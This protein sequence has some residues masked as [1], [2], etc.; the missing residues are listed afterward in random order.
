MS[1]TS[2][3]L[4]APFVGSPDNPPPTDV[5]FGFLDLGRERRLRYALALGAEGGPSRGT[6][7]LLQGRNEASE[8]YFETMRD[9]NRLGFC[10]ATFDWRGQGRSF[11]STRSPTVGHV[12]RVGHY[13]DDLLRVFSEVV[14]AR[15]PGPYA[16]LAHSMG[17]LVAL[18]AME[19]LEPR[20]ERMVLLAPF[21]GLPGS[22][23]KT[24][25]I[26][27]LAGSLHWAGLG[28]VPLRRARRIEP[29]A[30]LADNPL[31]SDRAR[32]ERNLALQ[33]AAPDLFVDSL[34]ASWLR[35]VL[36]AQ[37]RLDDSD[38]IAR[39]RIPT[40]FIAAGADRIVSK[41]TAERLAWRMRSG[42]FLRVPGARHELLQEADRFRE[43]TL[44]AFEAFLDS[45]LPRVR[46]P[47]PAVDT[48]LVEEAL[49]AALPAGAN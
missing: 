40:L 9:L 44:S 17:G 18:A 47:E 8:K 13:A 4:A 36:K 16:I 39:M 5:E 2:A 49:V 34:S 45:A 24:R 25:L 23:F 37:R 12:T 30:S 33:I 22:A 31:T 19:R 48:A 28:R 29:G 20:V 46:P 43:P 27:F 42:H 15:C 26:G 35:A 6:V 3:P 38:R 14:L 7:I 41:R 1:E 11:R 32:V 21:V 10:V